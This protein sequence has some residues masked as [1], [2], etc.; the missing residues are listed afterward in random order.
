TNNEK[1]DTIMIANRQE[2]PDRRLKVLK[3][4][5]VYTLIT[6]LWIVTTDHILLKFFNDEETL[7]IFQTIKG[8][9]FISLMAWMLYLHMQ[10]NNVKRDQI[11]SML[12]HNESRYRR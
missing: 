3:I 8:L 12:R 9:F 11:E 6:G 2:K 4:V 7:T 5:A 10:R 1:K